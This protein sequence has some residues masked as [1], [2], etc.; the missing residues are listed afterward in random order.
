MGYIFFQAILLVLLVWLKRHEALECALL[1]SQDVCRSLGPSFHMFPFWASGKEGLLSPWAAPN[2]L[3]QFGQGYLY[4]D[5][6]ILF[7]L[8]I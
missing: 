8:F 3:K 7:S 1:V 4:L 2:D 5:I 6:S